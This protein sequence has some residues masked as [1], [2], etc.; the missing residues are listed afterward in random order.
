MRR[1]TGFGE[2]KVM[3]MVGWFGRYL[4]VWRLLDFYP[5]LEGLIRIFGFRVI[6]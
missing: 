3:L 4:F 6:E 2:S 5:L 1:V